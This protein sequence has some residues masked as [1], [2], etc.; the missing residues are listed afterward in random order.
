MTYEPH[1]RQPAIGALA[2]PALIA[3]TASPVFFFYGAGYLLAFGYFFGMGPALMTAFAPTELALVGFA[4]LSGTMAISAFVTFFVVTASYLIATRAKARRPK[5][6]RGANYFSAAVC[7]IAAIFIARAS[8]QAGF[9]SA[10]LGI[11]TLFIVGGIGVTFLFERDEWVRRRDHPWRWMLPMIV[12]VLGLPSLGEA[13]FQEASAND[14]AQ[15]ITIAVNGRP[16]PA[17][18]LM[19]GAGA[20]IYEIGDE[21][22]LAGPRGENPIAL[23]RTNPA[24]IPQAHSPIS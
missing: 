5:L 23:G 16:T 12:L 6:S 3:A 15:W 4:R 9:L 24:D 22:Y 14:R 18:L 17:K 8:W 10:L 1:A 7:L 19:L 21:R 11:V 13:G 2:W 20:M